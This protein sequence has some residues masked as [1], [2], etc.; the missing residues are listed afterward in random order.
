[1]AS[2]NS[3]T[4]VGRLGQDPEYK[5][6]G[7]DNGVANISVATDRFKKDSPT[8]WHRVSVFGQPG[9]FVRDYIRKGDLVCVQGRI[10]YS[11]R[12]GKY[13]TG[14]VASRVT[15]LSSKKDAGREFTAQAVAPAAPAAK[16]VTGLDPDPTLPF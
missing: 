7:P 2:I 10:E 9:E 3:V 16:Q 12:D 13:Y 11:E 15:S 6:F 1:M 4:L 8:D 14:I 5:S